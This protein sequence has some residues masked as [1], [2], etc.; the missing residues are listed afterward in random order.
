MGIKNT[1]LGPFS[2][3]EKV[4]MREIYRAVAAYYSPHPR[5]L[6]EGEGKVVIFSRVEPKLFSVAS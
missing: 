5:P 4:R 6:P 1:D 3:R 2:L